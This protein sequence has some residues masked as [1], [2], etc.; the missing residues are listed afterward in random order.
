MTKTSD[1]KIQNCIPNPTSGATEIQFNTDLKAETVVLN[2]I[3]MQGQTIVSVP[4][5]IKGESTETVQLGAY[6]AGIYTI[7]LYVD[8]IKCDTKK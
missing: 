4:I 5:V 3:D 8:G 7:E 2:V 6:A 1:N